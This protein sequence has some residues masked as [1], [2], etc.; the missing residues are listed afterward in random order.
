MVLSVVDTANEPRARVVDRSLI[1]GHNEEQ[2]EQSEAIWHPSPSL[3]ARHARV[4]RMKNHWCVE[5]LD[6][7]TW[8]NGQR[9]QPG[10][11]VPLRLG[12]LL[13]LAE[14]ELLVDLPETAPTP[15]VAMPGSCVE[16]VESESCQTA[17]VTLQR[18]FV[19][20]EEPPEATPQLTGTQKAKELNRALR[21]LVLGANG[22]VNAADRHADAQREER[23]E[24]RAAKRR[25]Q[26]PVEWPRERPVAL[27]ALPAL[28]EAPGSIGPILKPRRFREA[29]SEESQMNAY[30]AGL[31]SSAPGLASSAPGMA[32]Q[33]PQVTQIGPECFTFEVLLR[34]AAGAFLGIDML[35]APKRPPA[36]IVKQVFQGGAVAAWNHQCNGSAFAIHP[37]DYIIRVNDVTDDITAFMEEMRAQPELHLTLLRR[38]K[39]PAPVVPDAK[40]M[41]M[42]PNLAVP[43]RPM[44]NP[45]VPLPNLSRPPFKAQG[46]MTMPPGYEG[47]DLRAAWRDAEAPA[48]LDEFTFEVEVEK[49]RGHKLGIDVMLMTAGGRCGLLVGQV[50][51]GGYAH[52]WNQQS[53]WPRQIQKNDLIIAAN[54]INARTDLARM[55]QEFD[56]DISRVDKLSSLPVSKAKMEAKS[57]KAEDEVTA[58]GDGMSEAASFEDEDQLQNDKEEALRAVQKN[59]YALGFVSR[60]LQNDREVVLAAVQQN[61]LALEKASDALRNDKEV[62]LAA[63]K[64][65]PLSLEFASQEMQNERDLVVV[66]SL[67]DGRALQFASEELRRNS[68]LLIDLGARHAECLKWAAQE[69]MYSK[70]F[71]VQMVKRDGRALRYAPSVFHKDR[72]VAIFAMRKYGLMLSCLSEELR[73]DERVVKAAVAQQGA[74]L[75]FA[76][77]RLRRTKEIV[78]EAVLQNAAS[79]RYAAPEY[80]TDP[81]AMAAHGF[82]EDRAKG[83]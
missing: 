2:S 40:R 17:G 34:K 49:P 1:L 39:D 78:M 37:G 76:S 57:R 6:G 65:S 44:S 67:K 47:M 69:L 82:S 48:P 63:V 53:Q 38:T 29:P 80:R 35:P 51:I 75:Q 25:R 26:H 14:L 54:G 66:A 79:L 13:R 16:T 43:G 81:E 58:C 60:Q 32:P 10:C 8:L 42:Q 28:P 22:V 61:G 71:W 64:R 52:L 20:K 73:D 59:G 30:V 31:A 15:T 33:T 3:C 24:D 56:M 72:D 68:E 83:R 62:V 18:D 9:L 50:A 41:G 36:L 23:Y 77:L 70:R 4:Y 7:S 5:A 45:G 74:A 12:S 55:A 19:P 27:P 11:P 21:R 46:Q